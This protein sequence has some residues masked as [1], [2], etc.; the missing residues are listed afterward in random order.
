MKLSKT[1]FD[2]RLGLV[3]VLLPS[4]G[5]SW[6]PH[7]YT[8]LGVALVIHAVRINDAAR[9]LFYNTDS[10]FVGEMQRVT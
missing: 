1:G 8:A 2:F 7:K 3:T 6:N 5:C 9:A 10:P 4:S